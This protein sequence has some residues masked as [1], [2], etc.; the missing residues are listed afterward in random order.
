MEASKA[1]QAIAEKQGGIVETV[2]IRR[3]GD[4]VPEFR[5]N[6]SA[7][8]GKFSLGLGYSSTI[9][10]ETREK[11]GKIMF[12]TPEDAMDYLDKVVEVYEDTKRKIQELSNEKGK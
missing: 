11:I 4:I 6:Q 12:E 3:A 9:E 2:V 5:M 10:Y 1:L 8:G 7:D